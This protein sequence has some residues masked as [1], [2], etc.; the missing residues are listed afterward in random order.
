VY[1]FPGDIL[2]NIRLG[3]REISEER[4]I[5][6][7]RLV[8]ADRF[9]ERLPQGYRTPV[10]ERGATL[11]VGEKQLLAFA[12]VVA[13]DPRIL[14]LDE[15]TA[16]IDPESE[17]LIQRALATLLEG[18]TALIIAH[19]LSTI[20]KVDR[21][22]VFHHGELKESGTHQQLLDHRGIYHR[23]HELQTG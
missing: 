14:I 2:E 16:H 7:A 20:R 13:F 19:R 10:Q 17:R 5:A 12:R 1:L 22:L 8:G 4:A 21:I 23:L 15:A 6:A 11:S 18:R 3:E 9:I